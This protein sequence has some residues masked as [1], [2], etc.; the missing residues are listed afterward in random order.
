M[1]H[2]TVIDIKSSFGHNI[3]NWLLRQ[4]PESRSL[5]VLFPG[6]IGA[7]FIPL[8]DYARNV[9]LQRNCDVLNIEYGFT[10]TE[11]FLSYNFYDDIVRETQEAVTACDLARYERIYFISKSYGT[12]VAGEIADRLSAHSIKNLFLTPLEATLP[13]LAKQGCAI[14]MGT[15]DRLFPDISRIESLSDVQLYKFGGAN[16]SLEIDDSYEKSL[17][18][19]AAVSKIYDTF[20]CGG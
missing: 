1:V 13:Y 2:G 4:E 16:H 10:R 7:Y 19:L 9:A 12:L 15:K 8:L 6:S 14:V 17:E 18:I 11:H 5:V 20:L 3:K